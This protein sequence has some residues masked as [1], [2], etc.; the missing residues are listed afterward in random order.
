VVAL[1]EALGA[2]ELPRRAVGRLLEYTGGNPLYIRAVLEECEAE[3][4]DRPGGTVG[5][6]RSLAAM[7]LARVGALSPAARQ[8]VAAAAV[9]GHHCPLAAAA[10]LAALDDPL[11]ALE[12]AMA[13]GVLV[14]QPGAAAGIGFPHLLVHRAVYDDLGPIWRRRLHAWAAGLVD[15]HQALA[16]RMAASVGPDD[17]LAGEL[18]A[19]GREA[20]ELGRLAQAADWLAQAA[21]ASSDPAAADRRLLDALEILVTYGEVARAEA[22]AARVAS[23]AASPRRCWLLGTLDSLAG[24]AAAAEARL[25]QEVR[26]APPRRA[27]DLAGITLHALGAL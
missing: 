22:L 18:E 19:A 12:E 7:V 4:L 8:L 11:P 27:R 13:A 1:G 5:V 24:R 17:G 2:G 21:A 14:E 15:R 9:L 20:R 23:A 10:A 6:P 25:V 16:H 3:G 26:A